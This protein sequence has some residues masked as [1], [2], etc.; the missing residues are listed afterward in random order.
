MWMLW[1]DFGQFRFMSEPREPAIWQKFKNLPAGQPRK[2]SSTRGS[3]LEVV[4]RPNAEAGKG[5]DS[6]EAA[7]GGARCA[8]ESIISMWSHLCQRTCTRA[9]AEAAAQPRQLEGAH[10][11]RFTSSHETQTDPKMRIT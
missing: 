10:R 8:Y 11:S 4:R 5:G 1:T 7:A 3:P 2:V 6:D 9:A